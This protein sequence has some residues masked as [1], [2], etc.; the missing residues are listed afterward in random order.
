MIAKELTF[1]GAT[2]RRQADEK[3]GFATET[4]S[5]QREE[6]VGS[7]DGPRDPHTPG[8]MRMVIK[9]KEL[10]EKQFVRV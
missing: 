10:R 8:A 2:K 1:L 6:G 5:S 3:T 9:I 4:Q 7:G